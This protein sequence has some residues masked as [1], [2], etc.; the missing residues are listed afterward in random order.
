MET[1]DEIKSRLN[2]LGLQDN[3]IQLLLRHEKISHNEL[4]VNGK[5]YP[6][7]RIMHSNALGPGKGGIRFHPDVNE[8]EIKSLSFWMSLK[9]ALLHLPL[10]GGKGGVKVNPKELSKQEIETL[11]R[12]YIQAFH[13]VL[14]ASKDIPAPDVYTTPQIMG[15]MLDEFEKIKGHKE[16]GMITGKPVELGGLAIR[17][18]ATSKGGLIILD[19]FLKKKQEKDLEIVIQGFGN[20]GLNFAKLIQDRQEFKVI[21]VSDSK[22]GILNKE[23][24]NLKELILSKEQGKSVTEFEQ[25]KI[26][27]KDL[28]ELDCDLLVLAAL[29]NQITEDNANDIK[30]KYILELAN[31][32]VTFKADGILFNKGIIVLPDILANAGG[33]LVS[34]FEWKNN[35]SENP[36][37]EETLK[38]RF[39]E[40]MKKAFNRVYDVYEKE[41]INMRE[42]AYIVA[43]K[44][45]LEA[46]RLRGRL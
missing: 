19:E 33:V 28:L 16:P 15:Y 3:E 36:L 29:E 13:E 23:G 44:R 2:K 26:Q 45:I 37:D 9:T 35:L 12:K 1:F 22:G 30:A 41:K 20:A 24:L 10:G 17:A 8:D 43:I 34:Y 14:G 6:A 5:K 21:A 42:A 18:D 25:E 31:G 38:Q 7:W 32:P 46:E 40:I 27:N 4:E 39:E 11:S